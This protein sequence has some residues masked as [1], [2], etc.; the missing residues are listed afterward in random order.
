MMTATPTLEQ[1][2]RAQAAPTPEQRWLQYVR[3][4]QDTRADLQISVAIDGIALVDSRHVQDGG[5]D[6]RVQ[7]GRVVWCTCLHYRTH[8]HI[9]AHAAFVAIH[10]WEHDQG[11]DLSQVPARALL[12]TLLRAYLDAPKVPARLGPGQRGPDGYDEERYSGPEH[13][14]I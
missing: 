8:G 14:A 12:G 9:C 7:D 3:E 1:R 13:E 2:I 11:V 10:L 5:H 6:V 4:A